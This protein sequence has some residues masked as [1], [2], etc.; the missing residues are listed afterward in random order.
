MG[1]IHEVAALEQIDLLNEICQKIDSENY[2]I[3]DIYSWCQ[4]KIEKL[5]SNT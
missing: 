2:D 1:R 3:E 5:V 4:E